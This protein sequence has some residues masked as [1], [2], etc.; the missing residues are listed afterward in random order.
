MHGTCKFSKVKGS[1]YKILI[2]VTNIC[3]ILSRPAV[4]NGL[5]VVKLKPD[6]K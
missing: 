2:K 1:I 3:N 5:M 6:L 4:S